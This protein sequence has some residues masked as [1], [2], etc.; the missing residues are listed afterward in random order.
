MNGP[1]VKFLFA[2]LLLL[3]GSAV[4]AA[5][6]RA[7]TLTKLELRRMP[8]SLATRRVLDQVADLLSDRS[9]FPP[10]AR[11]E[12]VFDLL[13]IVAPD[14]SLVKQQS[15]YAIDEGDVRQALDRI[16][17]TAVFAPSVTPTRH[18]RYPLSV[19]TLTVPY[20]ASPYAGLCSAATFRVWFDAAGKGRGVATPMRASNIDTYPRYQ[21]LD[22]R[23]AAVAR[24][25]TAAERAKAEGDC[26][27]LNSQDDYDTSFGA[28]D[29]RAAIEAT[30][31]SRAVIAAAGTHPLPFALDCRKVEKAR[32]AARIAHLRPDK[33][34]IHSCETA[35]DNTRQCTVNTNC[36]ENSECSVDRTDGFELKIT[37]DPQHVLKVVASETVTVVVVDARIED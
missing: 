30:W 36:M 33:H 35:E 10:I 13:R 17:A 29:D 7:P 14:S 21:L 26:A 15:L 2:I 11:Q 8:Q 28:P 25:A 37:A 19:Y 24:K 18:P 9:S 1:G 6:H 20:H 16:A 32:C 4:G 27:K 3:L 5:A 23:G 12:R 31:L 22:E 34:W